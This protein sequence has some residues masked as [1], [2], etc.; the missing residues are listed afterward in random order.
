MSQAT[1]ESMN[2]RSPAIAIT[3]TGLAI[4]ISR[5]YNKVW[6]IILFCL[7]AMGA[8]IGVPLY[9]YVYHYTWLDWSLFWLLYVVSGVGLTVGY[10]RLMGHRSFDCPNWVKGAL[11]IGCAWALPHF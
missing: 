3:P 4:P 1:P 10:H 8:I 9:G 2:P 6:T 5:R 7:I 11:L